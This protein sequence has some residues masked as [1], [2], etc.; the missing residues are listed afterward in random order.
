MREWS[1]N[2]LDRP[3][4]NRKCGAAILPAAIMGGSSILGGIMGMSSSDSQMA[5]NSAE[6]EKNRQFNR[7][8]ADKN[9]N[10]SAAQWQHQFD[11][12]NNQWFNQFNAQNSKWYDQQTFLQNQWRTQQDYSNRQAYQYWLAQQQYNSPQQMVS[13]L[14]SAGLNPAA[15]I[16]AQQFGSTGL[17]AAPAG[18]QVASQGS[19]SV[20]SVGTPS[21]SAAS[22]GQNNIAAV[23]SSA[24]AFKSIVSGA[25]DLLRSLASSR[26]DNAEAVRSEKTLQ[27][28]IETSL[29][30]LRNKQ[31]MNTWQDMQN[32]FFS[33]SAPKQLQK[34]GAEINEITARVL[35]TTTQTDLVENQSITEGF[36][37][38]LLGAQKDLTNEQFMQAVIF[39]SQ[40][41]RQLLLENE[42]RKSTTASNYA[43]SFKARAE[44]VTENELRP[45]REKSLELSNEI[46]HKT[47]YG[48]QLDNWLKDETLKSRA[49]I[50]LEEAKRAGLITQGEVYRLGQQMDEYN[51]RD[52][53]RF[54]NWLGQGA[55][56]FRDFG[57]GSSSFGSKVPKSTPVDS[58]WTIYGGSPSPY[59]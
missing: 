55:G 36:K 45:L 4:D 6:A 32:V 26:K 29:V 41:E 38:A 24:D 58:P 23:Q 10:W 16:N 2:F 37:Q 53:N 59:D 3:F 49:K 30:E 15:A 17:Q 20:P 48:L 5:T 27:T 43:Q 50:I 28:Y 12:Q 18:V 35:L 52:I 42:L 22:I 57:I 40:Y 47:K 34:L 44:G 13:R 11:E 46:A 33:K 54:F 56:A 9:R 19:P 31:L 25:S 7:E 14:A 21:G 39:T 8:E 51:H 1:F